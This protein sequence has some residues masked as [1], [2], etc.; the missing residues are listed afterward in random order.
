MGSRVVLGALAGLAAAVAFLFAQP[1][2]P[3]D[4]SRSEILAAVLVLAAGK[5]ISFELFRLPRLR[6]SR[7][8]L[9]DALAVSLANIG[10]IVLAAVSW[11]SFLPSRPTATLL[12]LDWLHCQVLICGVLAGARMLAERR[13]GRDTPADESSVLIYGAGECGAELL[14]QIQ[15]GRRTGYRVLGFIDDD[16]STRNQSVRMT[17]VLGTRDDLTRLVR[18]LGIEELLV[19]IPELSEVRKQQLLLI[20]E[21]SGTAIQFILPGRDTIVAQQNQ[22]AWTDMP[23]GDMDSPA[24]EEI[25]RESIRGLARALGPEGLRGKPGATERPPGDRPAAKPTSG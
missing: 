7:F 4:G 16:P 3:L 21:M 24:G 22:T 15:S 17:P 10:G 25:F 23:A 13:K 5:W 12:W 6:W 14:K 18:L 19:A 9:P 11:S 20:S 8:G 2:A 1:T